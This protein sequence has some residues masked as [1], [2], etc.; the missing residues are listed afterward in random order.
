MNLN[1]QEWSTALKA[2][3][4]NQ[5]QHNPIPNRDTLSVEEEWQCRIIG[6]E[7]VSW[8]Q[9]HLRDIVG[10]RATLRIMKFDPEPLIVFTASMPGLVAAQEIMSEPSE[11][12]VYLLHMEFDEWEKE[13]Q[14]EKF[15][16]HIHHWSYFRK[17]D[18]ELLLRTQEV[19]PEVSP[20]EYRIHTTGDLWAEQC[21]MQGE[22][23]WRWNGE[24]MELLEEAFSQAVY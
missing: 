16:F 7:F 24:E 22:H 6:G 14:V 20:E 4:Q 9:Q 23:L 17:I 1:K 11:S 21:G 12:L 19:Y 10:Q 3:A 13:H 15:I 5:R 18:Q 2:F 8:Y